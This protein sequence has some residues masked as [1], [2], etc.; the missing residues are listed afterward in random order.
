M[1]LQI[2][3]LL[4]YYDSLKYQFPPCCIVFMY[5]LLLTI[6]ICFQT[7]LSYMSVVW[8][9]VG[10]TIKFLLLFSETFKEYIKTLHP[11]TMKNIFYG[12]FLCPL[13]E[14]MK[15]YT[16]VKIIILLSRCQ[17]YYVIYSLVTIVNTILHIWKLLRELDL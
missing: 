1:Y 8:H 3:V 11:K 13:A 2:H 10:C 17:N 4:L 15:V 12:K 9:L 16:E 14:S 6:F 5:Y 7:D